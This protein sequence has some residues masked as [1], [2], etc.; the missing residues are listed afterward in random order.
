MVLGQTKPL[1]EQEADKHHDDARIASSN[2]EEATNI[3]NTATTAAA[4]HDHDSAADSWPDTPPAGNIRDDVTERNHFSWKR[5]PFAICLAVTLPIAV[6]AFVVGNRE[7]VVTAGCDCS[8]EFCAEGY[9]YCAQADSSTP[10]QDDNNNNNNNNSCVEESIATV[11]RF[12]APA[13]PVAYTFLVLSIISVVGVCVMQM[14]DISVQS[15][16]LQTRGRASEKINAEND[17]STKV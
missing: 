1:D 2:T 9:C 6:G 10:N 17:A 3:T 7:K 15:R 4:D 5:L 12:Q 11:R 13:R 14:F 8:D 16:S